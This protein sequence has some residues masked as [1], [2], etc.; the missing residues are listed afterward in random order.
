[1]RAHD[2]DRRIDYSIPFNKP[3]VLGREQ[4]YV[5]EAIRTRQIAADGPFTRRC[6]Q[7]ME[8][9]FGIPKVLMTPSCTAA[10]ELAAMLCDVGP[11]DEVIMP[12]YT[13]VSTANAVT[14]LGAR[15]VFVEIRPDTLNIDETRIEEAITP[16]TKAIFPVHYAGVACEMDHILRTARRH[17][18]RVVEDAAQGVNSSYKGR[19]LGSIGH[20]GTYS[21]HDTKNLVCG[22][23]GAL[24]CN[25]PEL[26]ERAEILRDKGTNRAK[27]FRGEVDKYTW[28]D[29]KGSS[30]LP[31][32]IACAFLAAQI[33]AK[34]AIKIRRRSID[35]YY[36]HRL[37]PLEQDGLLRLQCVPSDCESHFYTFYLILDSVT[38][39]DA[40][41]AYL[42]TKGIS[43]VFH[44]VPLHA[45]PMGKKFGYR[46]GDL[47]IT[48]DMS[49]RLLRLPAYAELTQG[50]Q[51]WIAD[52]VEA[53]L[54]RRPEPK[55]RAVVPAAS[56]SPAASAGI[57]R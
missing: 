30:Y 52:H 9:L 7:L 11:G 37:G 47:P 27:F 22:E 15:P 51:E 53:F 26:T 32:E 31:S 54:R 50:E 55:R 29:D 24:C 36:R 56:T 3:L 21:F 19:A 18:L 25:D 35:R 43:A 16:K 23:G 49:G 8:V 2:D 42:K 44:F 1:M 45:S 17:G 20:L 5:A 39:R 46:E 40:L 14:R 12:S 38:T 28:I 57:L 13:F 41:M 6:A 10:L 34:D 33:E 48:E 4:E